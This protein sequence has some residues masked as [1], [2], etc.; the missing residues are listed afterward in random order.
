MIRHTSPPALLAMLLIV[1]GCRSDGISS[2]KSPPPTPVAME[3]AELIRACDRDEPVAHFSPAAIDL[4]IQMTRTNLQNA[5]VTAFKRTRASTDGAS[6]RLLLDADQ[7]PVES[8][9]RELDLAVSGWGFFALQTRAGIRYTRNGNFFVNGHRQ[10]VSS[11]GYPVFPSIVVPASAAHDIVVCEDGWVG[12]DHKG[13]GQLRLYRFANADRLARDEQ[14]LLLPTAESGEPLGGWPADDDHRFGSIFQ[15][16]L[17]G[18]NVDRSAERERLQRLLR[19]RARL[20]G[21]GR[22]FA[23]SD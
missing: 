17:E 20:G 3:A 14:G 13:F 11:E 5:E 22:T 19:C 10:V 2:P 8:T 6:S 4:A 23:K 1:F 15:T 12:Y 21:E 9:G 16:F 7:G 18:S